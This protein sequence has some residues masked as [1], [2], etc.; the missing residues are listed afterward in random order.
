M[1]KQRETKGVRKME[2]GCKKKKVE[3]GLKKKREKGI[4]KYI[5]KKE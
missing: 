5:L 1:G 2:K 3:K 4:K